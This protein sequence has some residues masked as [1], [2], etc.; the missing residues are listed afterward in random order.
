[1][2]DKHSFDIV[3]EVNIQEVAN[4]VDQAQREIATR[5]DFKD[6]H[7]AIEFDR[8]TLKLAADNDKQLEAVRKV[9][10]ERFIKRGVEPRSMDPQKIERASHDTVRQEI[11]LKSGI[12][13]DTAKAITQKIKELKLR[14]SA[15]I[16]GEA[17]RVSGAKKDELQTVIAALRAAPPG[18]LPLQFHNYR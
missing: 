7:A 13:R 1:M 11:K 3:S 8:K 16:Q 12:D 15:T 10:V 4:A 9:L 14:V 5:Y 6:S 18:D 17:V 2:A